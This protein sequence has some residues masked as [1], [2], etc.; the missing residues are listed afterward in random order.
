LQ[1]DESKIQNMLDRLRV[2]HNIICSTLQFDGGCPSFPCQGFKRESKSYRSPTH[3]P[4]NH[5]PCCQQHPEFRG[6]PQRSPA[7]ISWVRNARIGEVFEA[8]CFGASPPFTHISSGKAF[9]ERCCDNYRSKVRTASVNTTIGDV[10]PM[11]DINPR[12]R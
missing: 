4:Q 6:L 8:R 1:A 12:Q 5:R 10:R 3:F 11:L 7:L 9:L 2:H